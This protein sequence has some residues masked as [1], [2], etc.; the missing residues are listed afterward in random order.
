MS[1]VLASSSGGGGLVLALVLGV[2]YFLP[3]IVAVHRGV[4]SQGSVMVVNLF[5]GWTLIGWVVALAMAARS[6]PQ[7]QQLDA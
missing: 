2:A 5:L 3:S 1:L 7:S 6:V 4:P